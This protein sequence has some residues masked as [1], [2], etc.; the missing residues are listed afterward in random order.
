VNVPRWNR[1]RLAPPEVNV[2]KKKPNWLQR[3]HLKPAPVRNSVVILAAVV[4]I[5]AAIIL[6]L[7]NPATKPLTPVSIA[8]DYLVQI[9]ALYMSIAVAARKWGFDLSDFYWEVPASFV[10]FALSLALIAYAPQHFAI[11]PSFWIGYG[12]SYSAGFLSYP[13]KLNLLK[14][15][16]ILAK[17]LKP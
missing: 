14:L 13:V 5:A 10:F 11:H 12:I 1:G 2:S 16:E 8:I 3:L 9:L 6:V 17:I 7:Q 15:L 4:V